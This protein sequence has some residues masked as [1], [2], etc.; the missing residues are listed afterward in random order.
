MPTKTGKRSH[1][2]ETNVISDER[3]SMPHTA[4]DITENLIHKNAGLR[5]AGV[6]R[7]LNFLRVLSTSIRK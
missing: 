6:E 5:S 1:A 7:N 4:T 2:K 3:N